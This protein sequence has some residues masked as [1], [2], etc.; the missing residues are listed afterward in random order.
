MPLRVHCTS[1]LLRLQ[2]FCYIDAHS[3]DSKVYHKQTTAH[4]CNSHE[5]TVTY[6][7]CLLADTLTLQD[8]PS[9]VGKLSVIGLFAAIF[10]GCYLLP[11]EHKHLVPLCNIPLIV[12][13]RVPQIITNAR[14]GHTG[15]VSC[16]E[17]AHT[18]C[19]RVAFHTLCIH[20]NVQLLY[21]A[22]AYTYH[23]IRTTQH[24]CT[25]H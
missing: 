2:H 14:N 24:T 25:V 6:C 1:Q 7:L 15:Q 10:A 9:A 13:S 12:L 11:D 19:Y 22:A 17:C 20:F 4:S 5:L 21:T 3:A 23:S 18:V 8:K 16:H